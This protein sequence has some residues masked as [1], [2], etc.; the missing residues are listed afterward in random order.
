MSQMLPLIALCV[1]CVTA[2]Q[3]CFRLGARPTGA[4]GQEKPRSVLET[5]GRPITLLG[6]VCFAGYFATWMLVL[7]KLDL[8]K[9]YPLMSL[10][11]VLVTL[12]SA[13]FLKEQVRRRRWAGVACIVL[14][15]ALIGGS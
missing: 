2:G 7:N 12:A 6:L 5:A 10:D 15:V 14:G 13:L 3:L 9:A 1:L 11:Y 4:P 8:G